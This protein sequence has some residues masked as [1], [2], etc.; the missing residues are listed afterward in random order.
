[1]NLQNISLCTTELIEAMSLLHSFEEFKFESLYSNS[2]NSVKNTS[3]KTAFKSQLA[4]PP[5]AL[6]SVL[7]L[8]NDTKSEVLNI[9]A[10]AKQATKIFLNYYPHFNAVE[11]AHLQKTTIYTKFDH[12]EFCAH[13]QYRWHS[14]S[15]I[16]MKAILNTPLEFQR[17]ILQKKIKLNDLLFL[18]TLNE[19]DSSIA[20]TSYFIKILETQPSYQELIK[21]TE[22]VVEIL[23]LDK[24]G[25]LNEVTSH[26]YSTSQ[27][28]IKAL[29][30]IRYPESAKVE[31]SKNAI[32]KNIPWPPFAEVKT[33]RK[34][35]RVGFDVRFFISSEAD[36]IKTVAALE[37]VQAALSQKNPIE[38][39]I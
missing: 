17:Y 32:Q 28:L 4:L 35:D 13:F 36:V 29:T 10:D 19:L 20:T 34:G 30:L 18:S 26:S 9:N 15:P 22:L 23:A 21:A 2:S 7:I 1:M 16:L 25:D 12:E 8:A 3:E 31:S 11:W 5:L 33:T 37:R 6:N 14:K 39:K 38:L 24:T 27:E